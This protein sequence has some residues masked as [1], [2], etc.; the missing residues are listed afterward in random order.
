VIFDALRM[1]ARMSQSSLDHFITQVRAAIDRGLPVTAEDV[2]D[3][4]EFAIAAKRE[5]HM[6]VPFDEGVD[7]I[8]NRLRLRRL[9]RET[10]RQRLE[11]EQ[12]LTF[13]DVP[14]IDYTWR[15]PKNRS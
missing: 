9:E 4:L 14:D 5:S 10:R 12:Q 7:R 13:A 6:A 1:E 3:G 8:E 11:R 15:G 2:L